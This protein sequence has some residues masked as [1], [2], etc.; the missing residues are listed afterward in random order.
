MPQEDQHTFEL[1]HAKK[2]G[3]V[4][5]PTAGES[6]KLFQPGKQPFYFPAAQ[7]TTKGPAYPVWAAIP[8]VTVSMSPLN[9]LDGIAIRI[10]DPSS[11]QLAI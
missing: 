5:F 7:V 1:D 8:S 3:G 2:V 4:A 9:K 11:A 6:A 10:S